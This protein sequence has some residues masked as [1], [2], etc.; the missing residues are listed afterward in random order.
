MNELLAAA[1]D[2][3][4]NANGDFED[5][6]G[7]RAYMVSHQDMWE[8]NE[9]IRDARLMPCPIKMREALRA[10]AGSIEWPSH[11]VGYVD[12]ARA[13]LALNALSDK[14]GSE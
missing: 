3:A 14:E 7:E 1:E 4:R 5:D 6:Q 13:A 11:D 10:I 12:V 8:M 2:L 9:A